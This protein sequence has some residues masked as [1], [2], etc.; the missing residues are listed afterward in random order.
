M[1]RLVG[2]VAPGGARAYFFSGDQYVRYDVAA[3]AV[4]AG[5]PKPIAGNWPGLFDRDIDAAAVFPNGK[6]YVLRGS[7]YIRFDWDASA[8]D[9]GYP[10]PID[11]NWPGLFA[12][13]DAV[14][15][16]TNGLVYF[17]QGQHY[18]RYDP[19]AGRVD[20]GYPREIAGSWP[21]LFTEGIESAMLWPSGSA[22]FFCGDLYVKYDPA[23]D[24]VPAGYPA[25]IAGAWPGLP[26]AAAPPGGQPAP[27]GG[28]LVQTSGGAASAL[29]GIP[30]RALTLDQAR[31]ELTRWEGEGSVKLEAS[32][33]AGKV[34]L[35]GLDPATGQSAAGNVGGVVIRYWGSGA[36]SGAA[37]SGGSAP[38]NL[39]PRQAVA[40]VR[41]CRWLKATWGVTEL[42]HAGAGGDP[43]GARTDCHGQGRALDF[44][45]IKGTWGG[46][47]Y[48]L[49]VFDDWG[50]VSTP[51][52]PGGAWVPAGTD[53]THF[54]LDDAPGFEFQ[55]DIY[56]SIYEFAAGQWQDTSSGPDPAGTPISAIGGRSFIMHPDTHTSAPGTPHGREAHQGHLHL[57]IGVTGTA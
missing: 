10:K 37:P 6:L 3:D 8:A 16:W 33:M 2:F 50:R 29:D 22:Y 35:D 15:T 20:D 48:T 9:P 7:E 4:D 31:G 46:T 45:G 30:A 27:P 19:D 1:T 23:T 44:V 55:R 24:T 56:R 5:Y 26:F 43:S 11:G 54:R 36:K 42:Y 17:F 47:D 38:D 53:S 40:L 34:S 12:G 14:V 39:D 41:F 21:G 25:A 18:S 51:S 49:T 32:P 28:Q 52:T 13:V 57:Q